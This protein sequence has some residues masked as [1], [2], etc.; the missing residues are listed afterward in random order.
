MKEETS[1]VGDGVKLTGGE[2]IIQEKMQ[3]RERLRENKYK[4]RFKVF[5]KYSAA[6]WAGFCLTG[7]TSVCNYCLI[8]FVHV[9]CLHSCNHKFFD[10][11]ILSDSL[12]H[13]SHSGNTS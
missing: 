8:I 12:T 7:R 5:D 6:H 4:N 10:S 13:S 3:E 2:Q 9:L 11:G 1:A